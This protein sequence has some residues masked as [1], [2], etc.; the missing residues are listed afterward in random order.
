MTDKTKPAHTADL[1]ANL[2]LVQIEQDGDPGYYPSRLTLAQAARYT[3]WS[4]ITDA[5]R[6]LVEGGKW[7]Y[8]EFTG[9]RTCSDER[10]RRITDTTCRLSDDYDGTV[11]DLLVRI[12]EL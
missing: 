6:G 9:D 5:V 2:E 4:T 3:P 8:I 12:V 7:N 11:R 1:P 10:G